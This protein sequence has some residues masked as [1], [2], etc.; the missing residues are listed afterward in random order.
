MRR[1]AGIVLTTVCLILGMVS[2]ARGSGKAA[3]PQAH[4]KGITVSGAAAGN[5]LALRIEG[6]Y[7]YKAVQATDDRLFIDLTDARAE[8]VPKSGA[9]SGGSLAGYRLLQYTDAAHRPVVRVQVDTKR[10]EPFR[11]QKERAGLRLLF[12]QAPTGSPASAAAPPAK[13]APATPAPA[14]V[15]SRSVPA[16]SASG[17]AFVSGVSIKAGPAGTTLVDIATSHATAYQVLHLENPARVVVDLEGARYVA[18]Q[19]AYAGQSPLLKGVR[20]GQF[21]ADSPAVVR[22]VADVVGNPTFD[23]HAQSGGVR[24]ELKSRTVARES[25][26]PAPPAPE[27]R[28]AVEAEAK[29][30]EAAQPTVPAV[31]PAKQ[32]EPAALA[33]QAVPAAPQTTAA[34][35]AEPQPA[36][37]LDYQSA[38]PAAPGSAEVTAAARPQPAQTSENL[39]A[40]RAARIIAGGVQP[41]TAALEGQSPAAAATPQEKPRYTGE[42]ISLNLKDVDLK[43]FFRLIHEISGL[44]IIVDPNVTG[45]VTLVLDGVP[46]DQALDLVL[47]N[48][49]LDKTLEGNVL[50]IARV[51]TLSAEQEAITK[52]SAAREEAQ[53]LVTVFRPVNYAKADTISSMLKSWVGGGA[54][55]KRGNILVDGRTNTLIISDIQTQIPI[56]ESIINKLDKKAKQVAIE[57]RIVLATAAFSRSL[58]AILSGGAINKSASTLVVG[59]TGTGSSVTPKNQLPPPPNITVTQTSAGGFGAIAVSNAAARY[60]LNA[61]LAAA[62]TKSEAKTISRP[63]IVTQNNVPGSVQQG[64]QIPIQTSINNTIAI[65]YVQ[66]TLQ[67]SVTPQVTE[68]GNIFLVIAVTN[69]SPG[70]VLTTAGPSINTQTATTQVLVPDGGTVVFGGV[71]ITSRTKSATYVPLLGNIPIFGHLFK[72]SNVQ[73]SDNELL[74]FVSP[75]VLPG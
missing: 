10:R 18:R 19:R 61:A 15:V 9:W 44:N 14:V 62:E 58:Q 34:A 69:A 47:R 32:T 1:K 60:V 33:P 64:S 13:R 31:V 35:S 54:L 46:W 59:S 65:Q 51:E 70:P 16:V 57:A 41:V 17:P 66:A 74:F 20:V 63:S 50:R 26:P 68:D 72:T 21:R 39:Q 30:V 73:D 23:V 67:L 45:T 24:I 40:A 22:V 43:D 48:N 29:P 36:R 52:L 25:T 3:P 5:E 55:T 11:V 71:T 2:T 28:P 56:I 12:G 37:A 38:L 42:P 4:L 75:K 49:R 6:R 7:S 8:G 27:S 53:P